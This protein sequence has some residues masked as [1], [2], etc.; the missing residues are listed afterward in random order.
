MEHNPLAGVKFEQTSGVICEKCKEA[1][2][3]EALILRKVSR[4]LV[5]TTSNKDTLIPVPVFY[6][7]NCK[8]VNK[9]FLPEGYTQEETE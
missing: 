6:C 4:F 1:V 2:F 9:E 7:V 8:H 5:A 3:S